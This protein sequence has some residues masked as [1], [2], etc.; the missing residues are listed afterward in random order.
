[1][2]WKILGVVA[3]AWLALIVVGALIKALFPILM[4]SLV[5]FG[6]YLLYK[7]VSGSN[8]KSTVGKI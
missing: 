1:M 8:N 2:F 5:V 4:I 6:L 3:L 7:A